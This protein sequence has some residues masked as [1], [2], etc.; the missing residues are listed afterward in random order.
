MKKQIFSFILLF[1]FAFSISAQEK[2]A[3]K[4]S[5]LQ[6]FW[7]CD[8][9]ISTLDN[10]LFELQNNP[11]A[12]GFI[13]Y[14]E[15]KYASDTEPSKAKMLLP[16]RGEANFRMQIIRN[17]IKFRKQ[18]P[19]RILFVNGGFREEQ[20]TEFWI[21]TKGAELPKPS[22]TLDFIEYRKGIPKWRCDI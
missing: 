16:K 3:R 13:I 2:E 7:Y 4:V 8:P 6:S 22:P 21:V 9:V 1:L 18:N 12:T 17:H 11:Q 14:Y 5:E 15:G 10:F 20:V 19:D